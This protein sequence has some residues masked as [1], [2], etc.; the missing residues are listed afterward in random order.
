MNAHSSIAGEMREMDWFHMDCPKTEVLILNFW[1]DEYFLPPF[2][3]NMPKL[4]ALIL[5]NYGSP[6]ALLL[7]TSVFSKLTNLRSLLFEKISLP[8]LPDTTTPLKNLQ[9]VSLV[10]CDIR[11]KH[12][13]SV[14]NLPHLF[15][16]LSEL[17]LDHCINLA[18]LP[19][20]ITQ[21]PALRSLSVTGCESLKELP[22][23]LGKLS[24]IQILRLYACPNLKR[25]PSGVSE[26]VS[27]K[28]LD[29][30]QCLKMEGLPEGIGGCT[31]LEKID[32]R[33]CNR[34]K[35][36][37]VSVVQLSSLRRVICEEEVA[38]MWKEVTK[39][40]P[41][42]CVHVPDECFTLDWLDE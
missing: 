5:I 33:E 34:I 6:T 40:V 12:D 36:L 25:L 8:L 23:D 29:I 37:P 38:F 20:T 39:S 24:S 18:D 19:S 10:L 14:T 35:T 15:P 26:L 9:K 32:M 4:R 3:D 13:H 17:S 21:M 11:N 1:S 16:R 2:L 22:S 31:K 41:S 42:L 28:Y 27:L 7:N 30:S